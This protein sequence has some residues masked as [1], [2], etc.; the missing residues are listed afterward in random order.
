MNSSDTHAL[1]QIPCDFNGG[2]ICMSIGTLYN[3]WT[4]ICTLTKTDDMNSSDTHALAQIPCDF[5]GGEICMSIGTLY[6]TWTTACELL[7][8]NKWQID[9]QRLMIWTVPMLMQFLLPKYHVISMEERFAWASAL[10][11]TYMCFSMWIVD[12][13]Q[14]LNRYSR[15]DDM[16]SFDAW[17]ILAQIPYDFYRGEN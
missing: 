3:T 12:A 7:I 16:N 8:L 13:Q 14:T 1:A 4:T 9:T 5:N 6:N 10:G 15:I 2:E 17:L 11:T